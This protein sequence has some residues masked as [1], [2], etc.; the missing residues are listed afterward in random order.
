MDSPKSQL[1]DIISEGVVPDLYHAEEV[2]CLGELI[3]REA[4]RINEATFG[5]FFGSLQIVFGRFL[6]LSVARMF[7]T[8]GP[9]YPIRSIPAALEVL[10]ENCE[11]LRLE[12]RA[13]VIRALC[14]QGVPETEI[15][16][17][18]DFEL[19]RF[20]ADFFGR[21]LSEAHPEGVDNAQALQALKTL[22]DKNIAHPEAIRPEDL[23]QATFA[24]IHGIVALA[25]TFVGAIGL[26]Y[27]NVVYEDNDGRYC[28]ST[29][30][31]RSTVCL[32]RLLKRAGVIPG[33]GSHG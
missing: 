27:L 15:K 29:D 22:R 28:M 5:S 9:R 26:G 10:R 31:E 3:G 6:I 20:L 18:R 8:P 14:R 2:L 4:R 30:A 7:E 23:P 33:D 11:S 21:R 12:E 1:D 24:Q 19:T 17:M 25:R 32:T 13:H 16:R